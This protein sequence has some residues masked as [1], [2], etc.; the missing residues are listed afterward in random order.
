MDTRTIGIEIEMTG[1]LRSKAAEVVGSFFNA[2]PQSITRLNYA[3][4]D[5]LGRKWHI[6][7]DDSII[8]LVNNGNELIPT[9]DEAYAIEIISPVLKADG[10]KAMYMVMD[11]LK[12]AGGV[13]SDSCGLH[14]HIGGEGHN[15]ESIRRLLVIT[16]AYQARLNATL[17]INP[18]RRAYCGFPRDEIVERIKALEHPA[19]NDIEDAWYYGNKKGKKRH[20]N[21]IRRQFVNLHSFFNG[22]GTVE[23]RGFNATLSS[24][25]IEKCV[26]IAL[27]ID[28][29]AR[30]GERQR[31]DGLL[32]AV[33]KEQEQN[34]IIKPKI[35]FAR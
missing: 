30:T 10:A 5:N 4:K 21:N 34:Y 25:E 11:F 28:E 18:K 19:L 6:K 23:F 24:L 26:N 14:V 17:N 16:H 1:I 20:L 13:V 3:V 15:A 2:H 33:P 22:I 32:V 29:A 27:A 35:R 8:L 12:Q 9:S 31:L 7:Y